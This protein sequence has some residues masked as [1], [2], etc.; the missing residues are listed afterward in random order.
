MNTSEF[1]PTA[2]LVL[3]VEYAPQQHP[4]DLEDLVWTV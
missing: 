1:N 3:S 2:R 4:G